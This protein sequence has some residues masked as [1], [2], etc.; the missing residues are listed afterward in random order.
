I[1]EHPTVRELY[2]ETL[3]KQGAQTKESAE[4][5]VKKHFTKLEQTFASLQ[6]EQDFV[7]PISEP[8][9]AGVAGR[10]ATAVPLT[11]LREINESLLASPEGFTFHKKLERGRQ[12]RRAALVNPQDRSVDWATA[13]ELAF[14]TILADG[15]P[16][17]LTGEDVR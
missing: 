13:E 12:R 15:V 16:I 11:R 3:I 2:A 8:A 10:T 9:P 4:E 1:D 7:P 5:L 6:P 17:R 14:A